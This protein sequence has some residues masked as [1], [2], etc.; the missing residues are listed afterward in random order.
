[1]NDQ[2][3]TIRRM[4][5]AS[6]EEVFDAWLD[7]EGMREW[8]RPGPVASCEVS[9]EPR[10]GGPFRIVMTALDAKFVNTGEFRVLDRPSKLQFTWIS[11]RWA[12]QETL[13]TVELHPCEMRCELVLTHE[14]F[15][16]EHSAGQLV[17][18]W[19]QILEKLAG[20]LGSGGNRA[21][22]GPGHAIREPP[23]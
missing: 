13:V 23:P 9:L 10:A 7:A 20:R 17:T 16:L 11:S 21:K 4:L 2:T 14:R 5:P 15:P 12:N 3:V 6:C 22:L 18:G 1:V 19:N 8:M